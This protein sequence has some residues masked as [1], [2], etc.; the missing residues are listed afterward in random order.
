[1]TAPSRHEA[2]RDSKGKRMKKRKG[3]GGKT[4]NV[5]SSLFGLAAHLD[6]EIEG[7]GGKEE[8]KKKG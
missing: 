2:R 3:G 5:C 7:G 1:M 8:E 6:P 4:G